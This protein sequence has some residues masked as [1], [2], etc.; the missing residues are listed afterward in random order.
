MKK[1]Y[2]VGG[3]TGGHCL[4]MLVTYDF[5]RKKKIKCKIITDKRGSSF[6]T[7]IPLKDKKILF[8]LSNSNNR[9][10]QI[11]NI[12]IFFIQ[13]FIMIL[14]SK[15]DFIIGFGGY[16]TLA[17]LKA[18]TLLNYKT[19]IHEANAI[20]GRANRSL[21]SRASII[22]TTFDETKKIEKKYENKVAIVGM[23]VRDIKLKKNNLL[24]LGVIKICVIGG[25]QGSKLLS[26]IVPKAVVHLQTK[27]NKKIIVSHQG[28]K[29][30]IKRI[31]NFYNSNYLK[32]D[33]SSYFNDIQSRINDSDLIISRSGSSTMNEIIYLKKPSIFIP[34][35]YA[36]DDHQYYNAKT[37]SDI[38]CTKIIRNNKLNFI[39]LSLEALKLIKFENTTSY[40]SSKLSRIRTSNSAENILLR[41]NEY[42]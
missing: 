33:V 5:L 38:K 22:F 7:S 17:P 32:S 27:I 19:A 14:N 29:E 42:K 31:K 13:S 3:G 1:I 25:S 35:P 9:I 23:P 10:S 8:S 28:R 37:L 26:E 6:F 18:S 4:P 34:F 40:V 39:K 15:V 16:M 24:K 20:L 21:I 36:V 2:L 12:P 11:L 30:D 41:L